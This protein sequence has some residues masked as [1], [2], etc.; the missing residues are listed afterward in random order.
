M[1]LKVDEVAARLRVTPRTVYYLI[2]KGVLP[3]YKL[4]GQL[5]VEEEDI[6]K[7]LEKSRVSHG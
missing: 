6:Q 7:A 3:A 5:R 2:E 4:N 1:L